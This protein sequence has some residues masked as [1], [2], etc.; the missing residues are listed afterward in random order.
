MDSFWEIWNFHE[1]SGEKKRHNCIRS[2]KFFPTPNTLFIKEMNVFTA[3]SG[4]YMLCSV[5]C[6]WTGGT[7][8]TLCIPPVVTSFNT[9]RSDVIE[10]ACDV[11]MFDTWP[12]FPADGTRGSMEAGSDRNC[13][14]IR[15]FSV[16]PPLPP[17][18][19]KVNFLENLT[20][21]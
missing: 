2:R 16:S 6:K 21:A 4:T 5:G 14:K 15:L 9:P 17:K 19:L 1:R 7:E 12:L 10:S 8:F 11:T 20:L 3:I 18:F 13:S